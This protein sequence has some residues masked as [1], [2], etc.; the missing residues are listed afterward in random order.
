MF[1]FFLLNFVSV[2][3]FYARIACV[4]AS[5]VSNVVPE[6]PVL[7][8][9]S[10]CVFERRLIEKFVNETGNDPVNSQPLTAEQ[11]ID[12]KSKTKGSL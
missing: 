4:R 3:F 2:C 11:L 7:S 10:G 12:I 6:H 8:P 1:L 5:A 9:V